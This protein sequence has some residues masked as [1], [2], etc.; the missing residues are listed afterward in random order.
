MKKL[1]SHITYKRLKLNHKI[2]AFK[3]YKL[4]LKNLE[5]IQSTYT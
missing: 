1:T 4:C 2:K 3:R 5:F